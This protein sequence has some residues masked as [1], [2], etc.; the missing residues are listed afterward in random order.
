MEYVY[1]CDP[2][3]SIDHHKHLPALEYFDHAALSAN[4]SVGYLHLINV[5]TYQEKTQRQNLRIADAVVSI[6]YNW[7]PKTLATFS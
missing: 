4:R 3:L 5:N 2:K 1:E 7:E 6:F